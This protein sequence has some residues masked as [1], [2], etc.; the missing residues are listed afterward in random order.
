MKQLTPRGAQPEHQT[1]D[2]FAVR[3]AN[4]KLRWFRYD[5]RKADW[6]RVAGPERYYKEEDRADN[7]DDP[8]ARDADFYYDKHYATV[9]QQL[10]AGR[11]WLEMRGSL[12]DHFK[13]YLSYA[14][15]NAKNQNDMNEIEGVKRLLADLKEIE[16]F[17]ELSRSDGRRW[18]VD[19]KR[20]VGKNPFRT[21]TFLQLPDDMQVLLG[22]IVE[23]SGTQKYWDRLVK[24]DH[25]FTIRKIP[26]A[27]IPD[28]PI[29]Q[30]DGDERDEK[31]ARRMIGADT[32]PIVFYKNIW[33]DGKHRVWAA[34]K[35]GL[36]TIDAIDLSELGDLNITDG[37]GKASLNPLLD[38]QNG[39]A[40]AKA[41]GDKEAMAA[42]SAELKRLRG[43]K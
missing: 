34:K 18:D 12:V 42:L 14:R 9:A 8:Y 2:K 41:A 27:S 3:Q 10:P 32:P 43:V 6:I 40:K 17:D 29:G 16:S 24:D 37:M 22:Q 33:L 15:T 39:L 35:S 38:L 11:P 26:V 5:T 20:W 4:G 23:E 28:E 21:I 13:H 36:K 25:I 19:A 31:Y 1:E 7:P 30:D